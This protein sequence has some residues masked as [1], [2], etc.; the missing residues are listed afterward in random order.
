M[1][2]T[3]HRSALFCGGGRRVNQNFWLYL[4]HEDTAL[5]PRST[6]SAHQSRCAPEPALPGVN[7]AV[8]FLADQHHLHIL[9]DLVLTYR[10]LSTTNK[11]AHKLRTTFAMSDFF[12][13]LQ[14][15]A[16]QLIVGNEL[17]VDAK[18]AKAVNLLCNGVK[19]RAQSLN[20]VENIVACVCGKIGRPVIVLE[21]IR[22]PK[23]RADCS[24]FKMS[25]VLTYHRHGC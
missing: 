17:T 8:G 22:R 24:I 20:S 12:V 19:L 7:I 6:S 11:E 16:C 10:A 14:L 15:I 18:T 25:C 3:E 5:V 2:F 9:H 23:A 1:Q 4:V 21:A 13:A